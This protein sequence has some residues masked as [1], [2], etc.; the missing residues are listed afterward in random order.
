MTTMEMNITENGTGDGEEMQVDEVNGDL[1]A[2]E[3][4]AVETGNVTVLTVPLEGN[5]KGIFGLGDFETLLS[6]NRYHLK[7]SETAK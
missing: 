3:N 5:L 6:I 4:A 1:Q 2:D 7:V